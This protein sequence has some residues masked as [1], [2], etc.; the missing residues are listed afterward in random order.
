MPEIST[1]ASKT[2]L[3][4]GTVTFLF[5][6]IEGSTALLQRL[7]D[8]YAEVL[9]TH[10]ELLRSAFSSY[11]GHEVGTEGDAV[12]VAF[13]G[14]GDA[15]ACAVAAQHA[16]L[17]HDW[18]H[19]EAVRVRM[20]IH[21]GEPVLMD[22]DYIGIDVH[23]TARICGAAHGGQIVISESTHRFLGRVAQRI[24]FR[25]LGEHRLKDLDR[26]EHLIQVVADDL[27][28]DFPPLRSARPPSNLPRHLGDLVGRRSEL[29]ELHALL[30]DH[31]TRL[32][33]IS[34]PGGTGKTRLAVAVA[35]EAIDDFGDGAFFVDLSAAYSEEA[36]GE[37][38]ARS[39][40]ISFDSGRSTTTAVEDVIAAK[41]ML[42]LLDNFEQAIGAAPVV[43]ELLD[44]CPHL[45]ILVTSRVILTIRGEHEY[46]LPPLGLPTATTLAEVKEADAVQLFAERARTMR[47]NFELTDDNAAAVAEICRLLD[48]LPL[49]IELAA[50]RSK[51]LTP[52][53]I[54]KRL[55]DRLNLLTGGPQDAP[56]RQRALRT[57]I[58]WSYDLLTEDE[59]NLFRDFAVFEG[60]ATLDAIQS[61]ICP[62]TDA[63]DPVTALV[64]HSLLRQ[65]ET[66]DGEIRFLMLQTIRQYALELLV[67]DSKQAEVRER[68]ALHFV[69]LAE[70]W[71]DDDDANAIEIEHDNLRAALEWLLDAAA[72]DSQTYGVPTLRLARALGRHW[73]T[74]GHAIQGSEW[75]ERALETAANAPEEL[76][77]QA[78]RMLG[79]LMDQRQNNARAREL[80]EEALAYFRRTGNRLEQVKCLNGLGLVARNNRRFDEARAMLE[81]SIRMRR[82]IGDEAGLA[83]SLSNLSIVALDMQNVDEAQ[84]LLEEA[85]AIDRSRNDDWGIAASANNL[86]VTYLE[87]GDLER[88]RPMIEEA[89][90]KF[91]SLGDSDGEAESL[92]V[93]AGLAAVEGNAVRAARLLGAARALRTAVGI[94][95]SA[96]DRERLDR[97]LEASRSELGAGAF[98][99]AEAEGAEMTSDQARDY[100]LGRTLTTSL[101]EGTGPS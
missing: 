66:D 32:I 22:D 14:A 26:A 63:L 100:G 76:R 12:F 85:I 2:S 27:P 23:R 53:A 18:K 13:S 6:D 56:L 37:A 38:I 75:L 90:M 79:A 39:L 78:L 87:R 31:D 9:L 89:L 95:M 93:L 44:V 68:H 65:R 80:F 28:T 61:V 8:E 101:E 74:H 4:E 60:G 58:D 98:D 71:A 72:A 47:P 1:F 94:P 11:G 10:R 81:E 5:T 35:V 59:R 49:A 19:G 24:D 41:H 54:L 57:T 83:T 84:R 50:A 29:K 86:G 70:K 52:Q 36:V 67:N 42:L 62:D 20:G 45:N 43:A 96:L 91:K 15:V 46:P 33:T 88:S 82:E 17:R 16:L 51:L 73:Y 64:N 30:L 34:G 48:G 92:E 25:D 40:Q 55:D 3:P 77:A 21:T 69:E 7:G 99:E 97:W